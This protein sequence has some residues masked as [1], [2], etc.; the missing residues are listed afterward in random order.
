MQTFW[1]RGYAA[2]SLQ[3]LLASM[4]LSKSSL[5][6]TYGSKQQLFERCIDHYRHQFTATLAA[7]L[8]TA[9]SALDFIRDTLYAATD[10]IRHGHP[11]RGCL[12]MNTASEIGQDNE[13]I[14][15]HVSEGIRALHRIFQRAVERAQAEGDIP[16]ER[17]SATLAHYLVTHLAG[18]HTMVKAGASRRET[19]A[20]AATALRALG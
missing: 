8:E 2:T 20:T 4:G 17:D 14:A 13:E 16:L 10:E 7:R 11:R 15:R 5:Y 3:D 19:K 1:T 6:Q 9:P 18:L 12:I